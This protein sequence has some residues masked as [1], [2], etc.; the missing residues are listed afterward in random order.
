[1]II[2]EERGA[3]RRAYYLDRKSKRQIAREQGHSR[4]TIDKAVENLPP[5]PYRLTKPKAAPVFGPFQARADA[6]LAENDHLPRKQQWVRLNS[7]V[8]TIQ[9][10]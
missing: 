6:L 1:M 4:K 7:F 3:I 10:S 5:Q 2:V 9:F 8:C